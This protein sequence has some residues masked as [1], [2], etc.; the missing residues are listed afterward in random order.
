MG[1][2]CESG[3]SAVSCGPL[4]LIPVNGNKTKTGQNRTEND[5]SARP[6]GRRAVNLVSESYILVYYTATQQVVYVIRLSICENILF[7]I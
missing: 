4:A 5:C 1:L 2:K 6:W 7:L 3:L